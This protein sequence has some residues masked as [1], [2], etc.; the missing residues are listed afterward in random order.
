MNAM[1]TILTKAAQGVYGEDSALIGKVFGLLVAANFD[2]GTGPF[3]CGTLGKQGPDGLHDGYQICPMFGAD[4]RATTA[5]MR[6]VD[7]G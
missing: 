4:V 3:I 2:K 1:Q 7:H 5:F 6:K